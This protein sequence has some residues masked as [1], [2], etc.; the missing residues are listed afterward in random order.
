MINN[1]FHQMF[2]QYLHAVSMT[3][4][5]PFRPPRAIGQEEKVRV[6]FLGLEGQDQRQF[7]VE[8]VEAP[9]INRGRG[10]TKIILAGEFNIS[11]I[12]FQRSAD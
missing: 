5:L 7:W 8:L 6:V 10:K 2:W 3:C 11:K 9:G 4:Q 1:L 12:K